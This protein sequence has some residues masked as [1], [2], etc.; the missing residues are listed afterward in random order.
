MDQL[1]NTGKKWVH[2]QH[3]QAHGSAKIYFSVDQLLDQL[4]DKLIDQLIN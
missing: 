4:L 3:H 1:G 2:L